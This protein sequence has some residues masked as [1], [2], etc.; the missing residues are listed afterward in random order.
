MPGKGP[1]GALLEGIMPARPPFHME[2]HN[3][4]WNFHAK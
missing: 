1:P 3:F 4:L 2:T